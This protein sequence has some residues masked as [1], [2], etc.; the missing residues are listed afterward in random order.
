MNVLYHSDARLGN[1]QAIF[2]V[3]FGNKDIKVDG[4]W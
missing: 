2:F 4:L 3:K 1:G